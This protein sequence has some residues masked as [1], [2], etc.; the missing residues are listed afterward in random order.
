M[1][2]ILVIILLFIPTILCEPEDKMSINN[3]L[4][5]AI[6][7]VESQENH[8]AVSKKGAIGLMQIRYS[9]WHKE[10]KQAGIIKSK[11]CLFHPEPNKRAGA[12]ILSKYYK[13]TNGN[14][15][16]TLAKYSGNARNYYEK[17]MKVLHETEP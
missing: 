4:I 9:V 12:Y 11:Q 10:L 8:K 17:V 13:Q 6:I 15:K 7:K 1:K 2:K 14:L 3:K 16:A 5:H